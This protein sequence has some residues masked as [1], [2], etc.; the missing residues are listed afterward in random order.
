MNDLAPPTL[1]S[2]ATDLVRVALLD[3]RQRWRDLVNL[4]ADFAFET[5]EWGRF[6]LISPDPA[7]AWPAA[8]LNGQAAATLLAESGG[9]AFNPFRVT[10]LVRHRQAWLKRGDGGIACLTFCA[11]PIH[12]QSGRVTGARGVGLDMTELD[13]QAA[14]VAA[15]LRRAEVLDHILWRVGQEVMAQRMMEAAL[16]SL[17]NALGAEGVAVLRLTP[18]IPPLDAIEPRLVHAAGTGAEMI[19]EIARR[20]A[21]FAE[22]NSPPPRTADGRPVLFAACQTKSGENAAL[23]AWR[24]ASTT[25]P[26]AW[27]RE[28]SLLIGSAANVIRMV[29]EHEAIQREMT[30]QARTDPLTGLMNRRAFL[31]EIERHASRLDRE[32][33]PGTLLFADLDH[34]KPVND[35]LGHETGDQVLR[36]TAAL[37]RKTFRPTDLVARLSGDEFAV[38]LNGADHMTAA[39]RAEHLRDVAPR[40]LA[41][42]TGPDG[43]RLSMSIGI[44]T[45]EP[46]DHEPVDSVMRRADMA[47][48]EV[49]RGGR[50]HWRVSLRR[51][52]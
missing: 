26:R 1:Q 14:Q 12:D 8:S 49:K 22:S 45:R 11:A 28:D 7:L 37:L 25:S 17:V 6:V 40:E 34:F 20:Q 31:E 32:K 9:A 38:W 5:D 23:I 24:A 15:A 33:Q 2:P 10:A 44:A 4:Y 52:P 19:A 16:E 50:G 3:S 41:E 36:R 43:P 35:Q 42:V 47:M 46:D 21:W 51:K 13:G 48:Y 27:D 39:E 29:L 18:A 30:Q